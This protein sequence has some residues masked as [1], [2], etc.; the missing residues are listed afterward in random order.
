MLPDSVAALLANSFPNQP[1]EAL[2][3]T[4]G[5]YSNLSLLV[6]IGDRRC[7]IKAAERS[8]KRE[9]LRRESAMLTRIAGHG[10]AAPTLLAWAEDDDW[11]VLVLQHRP[12]TP[13]MSLYSEPPE[14]LLPPLNT[15]GATL[16]Q[17]HDLRL[18]PPAAADLLL[19]ERAVALAQTVARLPITDELRR[20]FTAALSHQAWHPAAP[21]LVHGDAGLHNIL[22]ERGQLTLLDWE[23]A[24]WG[25]P[26]HDLAWAL[27]TLRFRGLPAACWGALLD[28]YGRERAAALG[29]EPGVLQALALGQVAALV[30]RASGGPHWS[31]WL[32]RALWTVANGPDLFS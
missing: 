31:E 16:A 25:D 28:G 7:V 5:G 2:A 13:G 29:L 26:R 22:W 8:T 12:G 30:A 19:G 9:D 11:T 24:G 6:R 14:A 4:V 15:L 21:R 18:D 32:R 20:S 27:W 1:V 23:L 3:P 17:L 10:L